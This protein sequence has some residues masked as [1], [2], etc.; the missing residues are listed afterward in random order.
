MKCDGKHSWFPLL[1]NFGVQLLWSLQ[2]QTRHQI[3]WLT[4]FDFPED[5]LVKRE[6]RSWLV[7]IYFY[8]LQTIHSCSLVEP[9]LNSRSQL[10]RIYPHNQLAF[11]KFCYT[12]KQDPNSR[13]SQDWTFES[14]SLNMKN[15]FKIKRPSL[16]PLLIVSCKAFTF[17]AI[18]THQT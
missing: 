5:L 1:P 4:S 6:S 9:R 11:P 17:L 2:K 12:F 3:P 18:L 13:I 8:L 15:K 7:S 14:L 16:S 10:C